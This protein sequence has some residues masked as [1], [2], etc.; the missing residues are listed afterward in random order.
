MPEAPEVKWVFMVV[1]IGALYWP[2][3]ETK[4]TNIWTTGAGSSGSTFSTGPAAYKQKA[5]VPTRVLTPV[6]GRKE[7]FGRLSKADQ[8]LLMKDG[9]RMTDKQKVKLMEKY[10]WFKE[11]MH[12]DSTT[13]DANGT[14]V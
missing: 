11:G 8:D 3:K 9:G 14:K 7:M 5:N 4:K 10:G 13:F 1:V 2:K 6:P 12:P